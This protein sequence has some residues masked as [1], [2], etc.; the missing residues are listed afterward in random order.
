MIIVEYKN[1]DNNM[2]NMDMEFAGRALVHR[3]NAIAMADWLKS[4]PNLEELMQKANP[5]LDSEE[6]ELIHHLMSG[7]GEGSNVSLD[8]EEGNITT[9]GSGADW[10][11]ATSDDKREKIKKAVSRMPGAPTVT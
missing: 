6:Q 1:N 7:G 11:V 2:E 8:Q 10:Y 5:P 3:E 4:Q 9:G